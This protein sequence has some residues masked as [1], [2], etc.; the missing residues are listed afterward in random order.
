MKALPALFIISVLLFSTLSVAVADSSFNETANTPALEMPSLTISDYVNK[1]L[2]E[3]KK[4]RFNSAGLTE[5]NTGIFVDEQ[6]WNWVT[7]SIQASANLTDM[8]LDWLN[9]SRKKCRT[10]S[11]CSG[12]SSLG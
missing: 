6:F 4:W 9:A 1:A 7:G 12:L 10:T 5:T 2:I 11:R 3:F 8:A